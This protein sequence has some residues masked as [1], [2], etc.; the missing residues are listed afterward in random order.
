MSNQNGQTPIQVSG[1]SSDLIQLRD[2]FGRDEALRGQV[3]LQTPPPQD[4]QMGGLADV[5]MVAFGAGGIG[6]VLVSS[7]K[8]WFTTRHSD[9]TLTITLPNGAEVLLDGKRV[10]QDQTFAALQKMIDS[11]NT[12]P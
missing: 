8:T 5:L 7:L 4:G 11:L 6:T 12:A 10:K 3:H 1:N 9:L 2:W